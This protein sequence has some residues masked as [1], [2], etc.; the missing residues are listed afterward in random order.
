MQPIIQAWREN[1]WD[2]CGVI[3]AHTRAPVLKCPHEANKLVIKAGLLEDQVGEIKV[4]PQREAG[5]PA[6]ALNW[7]GFVSGLKCPAGPGKNTGNR[8]EIHLNDCSVR[9]VIY[10]GLKHEKQENNRWEKFWGFIE[11]RLKSK[12]TPTVFSFIIII[13]I[14]II[15]LELHGFLWKCKIYY[16]KWKSV[17]IC[18]VSS[19]SWFIYFKMRNVN[20]EMD[21]SFQLNTDSTPNTFI[22]LLSFFY[23]FKVLQSISL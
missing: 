22:L 8:Q 20:S 5:F 10:C 21:S 11:K 7:S 4:G 17:V 14:I 1:K 18:T 12:S 3:Y 15:T 16:V 23:Q 19:L 9:V 6:E 13:I 2:C